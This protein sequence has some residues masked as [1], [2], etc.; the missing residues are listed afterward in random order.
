MPGDSNDNKTGASKPLLTVAMPIYNA[1]EYLRTA[2]LSILKQSEKNWE[3]LIIDDG[4]T[5][6]ALASIAYIVD[7]R[8][9]VLV[10]GMNKGLACRLNE[11]IDLAQ[12]TYFARMDH[13]DVSYPQRF[14]KQLGLLYDN[15]EL[16]L[17]ATRALLIDEHNHALG[18]FP[19]GLTHP[20][21]CAQ[22]WRGFYFPHPTWLGKTSWF[23][24]HRYAE[25]APTFCEDQELLLRSYSESKFATLDAVLFAYRI[26][27]RV[28]WHKQL[29]TRLALYRVQREFFYSKRQWNFFLL[30][31]LVVLARMIVDLW[32][33]LR[34]LA[35]FSGYNNIP[36]H[37]AVEWQAVLAGMNKHTDL[38]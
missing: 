14:E 21:I 23:R 17:V 18:I 20:T 34:K 35:P 19:G 36:P 25:P 30:T 2:V 15:P 16:D 9:R 10:D 11:A 33:R 28:N 5:D 1:G 7:A 24:K 26:K 4:S 3:L 8:V 37:V 32:K 29:R 6:N 13:D 38:P 31:S 22:P 12:G 27:R